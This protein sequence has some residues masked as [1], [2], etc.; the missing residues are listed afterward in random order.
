MPPPVR[1]EHDILPFT[2]DTARRFGDPHPTLIQHVV[3][4]TETAGAG[5]GSH[6]HDD[7]PAY[8]MAIKGRFSIVKPTRGASES[9]TII[10]RSVL[11][12]VIDAETGE[13]VISGSQDTYPALA[14]VGRLV[15]DLD[16]A[17]P[18]TSDA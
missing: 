1:S 17:G 5:F 12:R 3:T 15:T 6:G 16:T 4:A 14:N 8:L 2:L 13:V 9:R 7:R 18:H 10:T 11:L